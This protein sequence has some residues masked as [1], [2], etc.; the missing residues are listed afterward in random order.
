MKP[1][2]KDAQ[3]CLPLKLNLLMEA[4]IEQ[5]KKEYKSSTLPDFQDLVEG[6]SYSFS[7][8]IEGSTDRESLILHQVSTFPLAY[9]FVTD[10]TYGHDTIMHDLMH[11]CEGLLIEWNENP[12]FQNLFEDIKFEYLRTVISLPKEVD[13]LPAIRWIEATNPANLTLESEALEL[14]A[15]S[16]SIAYRISGFNAYAAGAN[17]AQELSYVAYELSQFLQQKIDRP[18]TL[19]MGIGEHFI[20]ELAK[21]KALD[22]LVNALFSYHGH[23]PLLKVRCK[24]GWR[25]KSSVQ[26]HD[27]QIRQTF[28]AVCGMLSG[29]HELCVTPYDH[30]YVGHS[31]NFV[32]RMALNAV[33]ILS[34][35]GQLNGEKTAIEGGPII[36]HHATTLCNSVW[37]FLKAASPEEAKTL[38]LS[39]MDTTLI[40]RTSTL[41]NFLKPEG[42]ITEKKKLSGIYGR[43]AVYFENLAI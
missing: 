9:H 30:A 41:S 13:L 27:N 21:F 25:N 39:A 11:G 16:S 10:G 23:Q 14:P 37:D 38:L 5:L 31:A 33:H 22:W 1:V 4:W 18:I 34:L 42:R 19:E 15:S 28:E 2:N 20:V 36:A 8:Q 35:E 24:T 43:D 40:Q 26:V 3:L 32:R 7:D 12:A 6:L 17:A 29:A